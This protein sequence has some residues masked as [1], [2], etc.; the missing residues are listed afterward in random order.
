VPPRDAGPDCAG[1]LRRKKVERDCVP[2]RRFDAENLAVERS[3]PL[4]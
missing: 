1:L 3:S 4:E 2:R